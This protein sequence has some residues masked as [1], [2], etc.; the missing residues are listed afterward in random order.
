MCVSG[1]FSCESIAGLDF[2]AVLARLEVS[3]SCG[4][5]SALIEGVLLSWEDFLLDHGHENTALGSNGLVF[6]FNP[7]MP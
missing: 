3:S 5:Y 4:E 1:S 7:F 2:F 6:H